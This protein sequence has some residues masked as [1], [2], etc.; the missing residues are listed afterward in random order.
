MELSNY[1]GSYSAW[2]LKEAAWQEIESRY[3]RSLTPF[4]RVIDSH[5]GFCLTMIVITPIAAGIG[6]LI[7][8]AIA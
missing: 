4:E 7:G 8:M 6:L 5:W 1:D 2:Q 3:E